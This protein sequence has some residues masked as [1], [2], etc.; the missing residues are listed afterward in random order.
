MEKR[1]KLKKLLLVI[2]IFIVLVIVVI[3][4]AIAI[5]NI[6]A[7]KRAGK[8]AKYET[9]RSATVEQLA[10]YCDMDL[11][12]ID[13]ICLTIHDAEKKGIGYI[14]DNEKQVRVDYIVSD[15]KIINE[16]ISRMKDIKVYGV[17]EKI[18]KDYDGVVDWDLELYIDDVEYALVFDGGNIG[19]NIAESLNV[20]TYYKGAGNIFFEEFPT[21]SD[22]L[23][24]NYSLIYNEN[25]IEYI[26]E[27]QSKYVSNITVENI[28]DIYNKGDTELFFAYENSGGREREDFDILSKEIHTLLYTFPIED[29]EGYIVVEKQDEGQEMGTDL[30]DYISY[31]DIVDVMIYNDKGD[32]VDFLNATSEEIVKFLDK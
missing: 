10:D 17:G 30:K 18:W 2:G 8:F 20:N 32:S 13:K 16:L 21:P 27:W 14:T 19:G 24:S 22:C 28:L 6:Q 1:G 23:W 11:D 3:V 15:K 4:V 12:R 9:W 26:Y 29:F 25:L 5:H 7:K 31:T